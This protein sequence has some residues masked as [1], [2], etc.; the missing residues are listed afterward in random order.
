MEKRQRRLERENLAR[1]RQKLRD[2]LE[3]LKVADPRVLL[4][5]IMAR[6]QRQRENEQGQASPVTYSDHETNTRLE[7]LRNELIDEARTTLRRYDALLPEVDNSDASAS[8]KRK[9]LTHADDD[10]SGTDDLVPSRAKNGRTTRV[11]RTTNR[12]SPLTTAS[13]LGT[14]SSTA[15]STSKRASTK[16]RASTSHIATADTHTPV[17]RRASTGSQSRT[18]PHP[19]RTSDGQVRAEHTYANIH[20]RTSGGRF[21]PKTALG[22]TGPSGSTSRIN[23]KSGGMKR[24]NTQSATPS[25]GQAST[26]SQATPSSQQQPQPPVK[27][28]RGRP[29]IHPRPPPKGEEEDEE[30]K[31]RLK[32]I[33]KR[34]PAG[35]DSSSSNTSSPQNTP[36]AARIQRSSNLANDQISATTVKEEDA[37]QSIALESED[38]EP[39]Q[40]V[41]HAALSLEEAQALFAQAMEDGDEDE[42]AKDAAAAA[43]AVAP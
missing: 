13:R 6:D 38:E 28:P 30:R 35:A 26:T 9:K 4:E 31:R 11:K 12:G 5:I 24:R 36:T 25:P 8:S 40:P 43:A 41:A 34:G 10:A 32:V 29:R 14:A 16:Q 23:T 1:D 42:D 2:R 22:S 27:R 39:P 37:N 33:L 21:A 18:S 15:E 19:F 3:Q 20:A 17:K 7:Q